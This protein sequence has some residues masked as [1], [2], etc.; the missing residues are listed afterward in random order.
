MIFGVK[1][2]TDDFLFEL[3][4]EEIP[5][6]YIADAVR[7]IRQHFETRLTEAKLSYSHIKMFSTPRRFAIKI[8]D[9]QL[10]QKDEVIERIG[11][12]RD[13][14]YDADGNLTKAALG[15]LR[16]ADAKPQDIHFVDSAK[17]EKIAVN[18]E[19]PGKQTKDI[20]P[21]IILESIPKL[22]FPKSMKWGSTTLN[23]ARPVRWLLVFLGKE[24][25]PLTFNGLKSEN[26]TFGNRFQKLSNPI[27]INEIDQYEKKLES[28]FVIPDRDKRKAKIE[29]QLQKLFEE[30]SQTIM[31]DKNLLEIVTDLVE[32]PTAVVA[33]FSPSYLQLPQ[34]VVTSTLSQ[35]QKY[36]A[37]K[38]ADGSLAKKFVFIS[39]GDPQHSELIK[40][41]NEKVI[42]ARLEDA[43][44]FYQEDIKV[45]L[46]EYVPK[47]AEV[48]FQQQLGTLWEKTE[49]ITA[50][51]AEVCSKIEI[52]RS[53]LE[54][55][56]RSA[57]LCKADLVTQ[58]LGEKEFTKL[59]GYMGQM[60][61][62]ACGESDVV[63]KAIYEHYLPRGERDR[64]P[65]TVP[66]AVVAIADKLDTVCGIIGVDMI[67]TG[68]KDPFALRRAANGI[69]QIIDKFKFYFDLT[70]L[71]KESFQILESKLPQPDNNIDFVL[72]FFKQRIQWLLR[73]KELE[74]DVIESVMNS[75]YSIIPDL[76]KRAVA[77]QHFRQRSD[78]IKLVLGFKRVSNIIAEHIERSAVDENLLQE[79]SE[80]KLYHEFKKL[81][82]KAQEL[83][84]K[85]KYD[86]V[87][88]EL[89]IFGTVIDKF[90]D[91][92]LVNV[93][94]E[95]LRIN[96]YNLLAEIR[97]LFLQIADISQIVI[98]NE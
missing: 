50:I 37:V 9:L 73:N 21:Q 45:G 49:R 29:R 87:L 98:E 64:L 70:E 43:A 93:E 22:N 83:L 40:L 5:A 96:R 67:P 60:Y 7:K 28:V 94:A 6:G 8:C 19:V 65:A 61:A 56:K 55:V 32:Y 86:Q 58:M 88:E 62:L 16:G 1:M 59:Q 41:G 95:N 18:R 25:L 66:G 53:D 26:I 75:S 52:T 13:V 85:Q 69:V 27:R 15:F 3:G 34:K 12:A 82:F 46:E 57:H 84:S 72:D 36:F 68:S 33:H 91:D 30:N 51:A 2:P 39:N 35:H 38:N 71:I 54:A 23:F 63:A 80:I 92:V 74:Y 76:V 89:V 42:T 10:Q 90:F 31:E 81:Q 48:T 97:Q 24:V 20:L 11:P 78:F 4:V 17:G 14:A 79:D 47:L 77:L 44:F